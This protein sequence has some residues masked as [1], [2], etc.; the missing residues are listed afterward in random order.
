M[1]L[2]VVRVSENSD[3]TFGVL[4]KPDGTAIAVTLELPWKNNEIGKSRIFAGTYV[5]K[6]FL[7]PKF[8]ME[9]FKLMGVLGR[10]NVLL[11]PANLAVQL[12][13]CIAIGHGF[14]FVSPKDRTGDDGIVNSGKEF[15]EFMELQK[16]TDTFLLT[17]IDPP[18]AAF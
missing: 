10:T 9:V 15:K 17:V 18:K 3:S 13:G 4:V 7:S 2:T 1:N 11:H 16:G 12:E 5:C 14:D 6:R 8:K